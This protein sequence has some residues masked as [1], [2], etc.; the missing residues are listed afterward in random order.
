ML[1][2]LKKRFTFIALAIPVLLFSQGTPSFAV[3][4]TGTATVVG[5]DCSGVTGSYFQMVSST[6][7]KLSNFNSPC[8]DQSVNPLTGTTG[9][10]LGSFQ[11]N[12][13]PVPAT[14][15]PDIGGNGWIRS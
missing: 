9:L 15:V 12:G 2:G 13:V 10:V 1:F 8:A 5:G 7:G 14:C 4:L 3:P 11:N 6:G